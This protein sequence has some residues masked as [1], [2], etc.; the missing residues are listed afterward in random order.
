MKAKIINKQEKVEEILNDEISRPKNVNILN[1]YVDHKTSS[2]SNNVIFSPL[3]KRS[4]F[5]IK[6]KVSDKLS[7]SYQKIFDK[8]ISLNKRTKFD[9]S[10]FQ[11]INSLFCKSKDY[12]VKE[13]KLA[14]DLLEKKSD[15]VTYMKTTR[16]FE[17]LKHLILDF[18]Q[19]YSLNYM[20]RLTYAKSKINQIK[21]K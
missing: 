14:C 10:Y 20:E 12:Q 2:K 17:S 4:D 3:K 13:F 9:I 18:Y 5:T 21:Q 6:N 1:N 16:Q 19:N 11:Y 15:I 8:T 7:F